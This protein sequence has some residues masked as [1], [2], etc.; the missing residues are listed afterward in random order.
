MTA[1]CSRQA[2]SA[3]FRRWVAMRITE[4]ESTLTERRTGLASF[5]ADLAVPPPRTKGPSQV[6]WK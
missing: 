1:S 3:E 6:S 2:V 4:L 5:D